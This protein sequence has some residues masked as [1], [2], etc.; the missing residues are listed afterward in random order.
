M[1]RTAIYVSTFPQILLCFLHG[2]FERRGK[3]H[4]ARKGLNTK[5]AEVV[6]EEEELL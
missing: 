6:T 5:Q 2:L 4:I 3:D 1:E